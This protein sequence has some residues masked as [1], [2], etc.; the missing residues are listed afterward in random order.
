MS[1]LLPLE[2]TDV[3]HLCLCASTDHRWEMNNPCAA[4]ARKGGATDAGQWPG[5]D[6]SAVT[7]PARYGNGLLTH[8]GK[9]R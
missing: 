7:E 1:I 2:R 5:N 9:E 4:T 3:I 6:A 8:R